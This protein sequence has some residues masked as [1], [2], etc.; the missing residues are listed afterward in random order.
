MGPTGIEPV[1]LAT[2][3]LKFVEAMSFAGL[4]QMLDAVKLAARPRA[5]FA[6][7]TANSNPL[8]GFELKHAN[9]DFA[10]KNLLRE[11]SR[12]LTHLKILL[13]CWYI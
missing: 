1:I 9:S 13:L 12:I 8:R 4:L 11:L 5:Q 6:K 2:S 10:L 3:N 7:N